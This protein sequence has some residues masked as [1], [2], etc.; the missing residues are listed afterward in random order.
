M[1][2]FQDDQSRDNSKMLLSMYMFSSDLFSERLA[3][4][5]V[6]ILANFK[7]IHIGRHEQYLRLLDPRCPLYFL[8][9]SQHMCY[10][11]LKNWVIPHWQNPSGDTTIACIGL[12]NHNVQGASQEIVMPYILA[13]VNDG[14]YAAG[15]VRDIHSKN[16]DAEMDKIFKHIPET[17]NFVIPMLWN[18]IHGNTN[19]YL[20]FRMK[21][22]M[23]DDGHAEDV[24]ATET[25][26]LYATYFI[27]PNKKAISKRQEIYV[28]RYHKNTVLLRMMFTAANRNFACLLVD[29]EYPDMADCGVRVNRK[30]FSSSL[31]GDKKSRVQSVYDYHGIYQHHVLFP[32]RPHREGF[33]KTKWQ[34]TEIY[35]ALYGLSKTPENNERLSNDT[36]LKDFGRMRTDFQERQMLKL[37]PEWY[38]ELF[39]NW[40]I[41][42]G[43]NFLL[44]QALFLEYM[45]YHLDLMYNQPLAEIPFEQH[46]YL[47]NRQYEKILMYGDTR[48]WEIEFLEKELG[49]L[50]D[51]YY[52]ADG[53]WSYQKEYEQAST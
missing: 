26:K 3:S 53:T 11:S 48:D 19:T 38:D 22:M 42:E 10:H 34:R 29:R 1:S 52:T 16:I 13:D 36:V 50:G 5:L 39:A 27:Q 12:A 8:S 24:I 40:H 18:G 47:G 7:K 15:V 33:P 46:K 44:E 9:P 17:S 4:D 43:K 6:P 37:D 14:V 21:N 25:Q 35:P 49:D 20:S 2:T 41:T 23:D 28:D 32:K 45:R 51:S 31:L 30:N